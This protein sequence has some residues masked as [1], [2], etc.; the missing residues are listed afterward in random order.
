[1][2]EILAY[3]LTWTTYGTWLPG[4]ERCSVDRMHN[5]PDTDYVFP[6]SKRYEANQSRMTEPPLYLTP[7]QREIIEQ[8]IREHCVY[9]N[10]NLIEINCRTNHIHVILHASEKSPER[11]MASLKARATLGLR[12]A[13]A[14]DQVNTWTRHGSTRYIKDS[15]SLAK[16]IEYVRGQ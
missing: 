14:I 4:D 7:R 10:W 16:A 15:D 11:V 1:M 3:F 8:S 2:S 6:D 9:K 12:N 5:A 13:K